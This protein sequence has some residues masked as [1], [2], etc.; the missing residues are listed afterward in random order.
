[1]YEMNKTSSLKPG[2]GGKGL[3]CLLSWLL[4]LLLQ[5]VAQGRI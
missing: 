4:L 5:M 2:T 1:M 3:R